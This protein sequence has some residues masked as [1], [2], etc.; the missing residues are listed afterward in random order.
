MKRS[1]ALRSKPAALPVE[2]VLPDK[3]YFRMREVSKLT[4]TEPYVLRFWE[5]KFP[6]LKP[7]K[8]RSGHRLFR[9]EDIRTILEIRNLL[10]T[11][12]FTIAGARKRLS[13]ESKKSAASRILAARG[14]AGDFRAVQR[15]LERILTML[16][17]RC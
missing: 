2:P 5:T 7:T 4:R 16:S 11:Q 14:N 3:L 12:G 13:S 9:R 17:R 8:T 6:Q 10:Y 1:A 15:E